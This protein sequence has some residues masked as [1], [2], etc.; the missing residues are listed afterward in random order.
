MGIVKYND[1]S[2]KDLDLIV[3]FIPTYSFAEKDISIE[4]VSGRNGDII[5]NNNCY[6][7][8]TI[9]YYLAKIFRSG[10]GFVAISN[11]IAEWLHS[12]ESYAKLEDSYEPDYYRMAIFKNSGELS[13]YYDQATTIEV[14]F[15]CKPQ[16]WLKVG[17]EP[18][19]ISNID[20]TLKNPT[21]YNSK[22][23]I[24]F[25]VASNVTVT[26]YVGTNT[27]TLSP[28]GSN[29]HV[30]ID[31]EN[32]ECYSSTSNLNKYLTLNSNDFPILEKNSSTS[33][34]IT[35]ATNAIIKPRWWTL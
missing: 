15:E 17:D 32:M 20:T 29:T 4:H 18:V 10:E 14:Q 9:T 25:D 2:T 26:I 12:S 23:I 33:V 19:N 35:N 16:K 8:V 22:P 1:I 31:C 27:M 28:T 21:N 5:I 7:N 30:I 24:E 3:Q 6:K 34:R 11:K 13:N